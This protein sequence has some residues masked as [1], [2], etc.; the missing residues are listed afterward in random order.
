M[1]EWKIT[2]NRV[3]GHGQNYTLHNKITAKQLHKTLTTYEKTQTLNHNI[4]QQYHKITKQLIQTQ[5]SLKILQHDIEQ[6]NKE[7]KNV[8]PN[9]R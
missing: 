4:E 5:L 2:D 1:S 7:V 9:K 6:L 3:H 8:S